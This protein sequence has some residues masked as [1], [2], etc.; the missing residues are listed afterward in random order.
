MWQFGNFIIKRKFAKGMLFIIKI[1]TLIITTSITWNIF[2]ASSILK[3]MEKKEVKDQIPKKNWNIW[4]QFDHKQKNGIV[5]K[6]EE[7]GIV[8]ILKIISIK[9]KNM[10]VLYVIEN[11]L[12]KHVKLLYAA[13][14]VEPNLEEKER[15][16]LQENVL[17]AE[18]NLLVNMQCQDQK[19]EKLA[20]NYAHEELHCVY[21]LTVDKDNVYYA[22]GILVSNCDTAYDACKLA[23]IDKTLLSRIINKPRD[24][25]IARRIMAT[26]NSIQA[27]RRRAYGK[28]NK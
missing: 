24:A 14:N 11:L 19:A 13:R 26:T 4:H 10:N 27:A 25:Q 21:N 12:Q 7:N 22:N 16:I 3:C 23:L 17:S 6:K 20:Q 18:T 2:R 1:I 15:Q 9:L 28:S 5:V 8:K